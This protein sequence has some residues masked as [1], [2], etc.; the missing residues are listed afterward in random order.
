MSFWAELLF[1][2]SSGASAGLSDSSLPQNQYEILQVT[3]PITYIGRA[4]LSVDSERLIAAFRRAYW[5]AEGCVLAEEEVGWGRYW[6]N[7]FVAFPSQTHADGFTEKFRRIRGEENLGQFVAAPRKVTEI[8]VKVKAEEEWREIKF[9][10]T[11]LF[12][13]A[14]EKT[15]A[16]GAIARF[17][18]ISKNAADIEIRLRVR[19]GGLISNQLQDV[20]SEP[21]FVD[22]SGQVRGTRPSDPD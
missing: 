14:K 11:E 15:F 6:W 1:C 13:L 12:D 17:K 4:G 3:F 20:W 2:V 19:K 18:T 7:Y 9:A 21:I 5:D 8:G 22:L 10:P 16:P